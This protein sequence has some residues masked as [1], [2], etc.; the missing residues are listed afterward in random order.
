MT[1]PIDAIRR[2]SAVRRPRRRGRAARRAPCRRARRG[3]CVTSSC[4]S[5]RSSASGPPT[6]APPTRPGRT[7]RPAIPTI[8]STRARPT[9]SLSAWMRA[10]T[11]DLV[12]AI[13]GAADD[14]PCWTWWGEPRDRAARSRATR[15]RRPRCTGGTRSRRPAHRAPIDA[16]AAA[17]AVDEFLAVSLGDALDELQGSVTLTASD[18]G[19]TW[20]VGPRRRTGGRHRR[21]RVGSAAR[22]VPPHR[23][24]RGDRR[25]RPRARSDVPR[26]AEHRVTLAAVPSACRGD[27]R[28]A[29]FGLFRVAPTLGIVGERPVRSPVRRSRGGDSMKFRN[30]ARVA[31]VLAVVGVLAAC[32]SSGGSKSSGVDQQQRPRRQDRHGRGREPVPAVQLHQQGHEEGRGLGLRHLAQDL[33]DHQVQGRLQGDR[34][35]GDDPGRLRQPVRRRGRRHHHH[36][37]ARQGRRLLARLHQGRAAADGEEGRDGVHLAR[38]VQEG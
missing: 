3:R 12:A 21:H 30:T 33:H 6:S 5:A 31:I 32:G 28:H 34:L 4:T 18:T 11:D 26:L 20:T 9:P 25:G 15:C 36:A 27:D 29:R 7:E 16:D 1:D 8:P 13:E 23:P 22:A 24:R 19:A 17:D 37:R 38:R 14:A 35:R 10:S 2:E